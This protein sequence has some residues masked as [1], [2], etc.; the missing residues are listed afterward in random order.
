MQGWPKSDT[1]L[2]L[3]KYLSFLAGVPYSMRT[4][5]PCMR[6][7]CNFVT[8]VA[9]TNDERCLIHN[10]RVEKHWGSEKIGL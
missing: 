7:N 9:L 2:D 3:V 4:I 6:T 5:A 8:L 1:V 10:M